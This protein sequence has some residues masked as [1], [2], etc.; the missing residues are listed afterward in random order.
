MAIRF[1]KYLAL[2]LLALSSA[3]YAANPQPL[4]VHQAFQ[5][6]GQ[7]KDSQTIQLHWQIAKNHYLYKDRFT[8]QI[9]Q[10]TDIKLTKIQMPQGIDK[11]D[12]LISSYTVYEDQVDLTLPLTR[13][14]PQ[15][16]INLKI[17]YQGCSL[18][19]YCYP[20]QTATLNFEANFSSA[21]WLKAT[22]VNPQNTSTSSKHIQQL[23]ATQSIWLILLSFY[24][25][26]L[27]LAFTPCVLPMVPLL[28]SLIVGKNHATST[29][30]FSFV[31]V[32]AMA[33]TYAL[34]GLGAGL[35]GASV[36]TFL[37]TPLVIASMSLLLVLFALS[38]FGLYE[39]QLPSILTQKLTSL[40]NKQMGGKYGSVAIMGVLSSLILSPCITPPLMGA[41]T[42]IS[43]TG[44]GLL[45]ALALL[46]IGYGMGTPL[47]II[48]T[49]M[50]HLLPR[51]GQWMVHIKNLCGLLLLAVAISLLQRIGSDVM[52]LILWVLWFL[53]TA[54][55]I[56]VF[57]KNQK[58]W[59]KIVL[60][61]TSFLIASY[62]I[63]LLITSGHVK[64]SHQITTASFKEVKNLATL[65]TYLH[66]LPNANSIVMLD[67]YADWCIS[68]QRMERDTFP[69]PQVQAELKTNRILPLRVDITKN[70]QNA[71]SI[72]NHYHII[73]P[74]T[75]IFLDK[76]GKE[77]VNFRLVGEVKP[78]G[79]SD[80]I[81]QVINEIK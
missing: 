55:F 11:E 2:G 60:R 20:P 52:I 10:P 71:N 81:Q 24:G 34:A 58:R 18:A 79:L 76:Q 7:I 53:A 26:G 14:I 63:S 49:S 28:S 45:G 31:Y 64:S 65:K 68:C 6:A 39:L 80:N 43:Q 21:K 19:N 61:V 74:P 78:Q 41:L 67:F 1:F 48:G 12:E 42:Y 70:D 57:S 29:L 77:L 40:S 25:F 38:L 44:N 62:S 35:L 30:R 27:L 75:I 13:P 59:L 17:G 9:T 32:S 73:A 22:P 23:L 3:A 5:L 33:F 69:D 66:N 50:G 54:G 51:A 16:G 46:A 47:L 37:Q 72:K 36:Q 4:P 56:L 15:Q 8:F